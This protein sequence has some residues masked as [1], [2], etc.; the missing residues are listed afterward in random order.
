MQGCPKIRFKFGGVLGSH[1]GP[2]RA[3]GDP[4]G[5][6]WGPIGPPWGP[7]TPPHIHFILGLPELSIINIIFPRSEWDH[8]MIKLASN[9]P[10]TFTSIPQSSH[11]QR[12]LSDWSGFWPRQ[13]LYISL[14]VPFMFRYHPDPEDYFRP[15]HY[16]LNKLL[17]FLP[18]LSLSL[19]S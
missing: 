17:M 18:C 16:Y 7:G 6:P 9:S 19:A 11:Q 3:H 12:P 14:F 1:G 15:T 2:M 4:M 8:S 13:V 10:T 5:I